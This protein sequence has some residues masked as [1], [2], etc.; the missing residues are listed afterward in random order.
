MIALI[1]ACIPLLVLIVSG[2]IQLIVHFTSKAHTI[3]VLEAQIDEVQKQLAVALANSDTVN[4]SLCTIELA[5]L[6]SE[7]NHINHQ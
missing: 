1:T 4:I 7:L 2:I 5:R 6:R 3:A